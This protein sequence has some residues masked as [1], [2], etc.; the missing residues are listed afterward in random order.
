MNAIIFGHTGQDGWYLTKLLKQK[1]IQVYGVSRSK[2]DL[3]CS[4]DEYDKLVEVLTDIKPDYIFH[5]AAIS[6]T[7]HEYLF[8]N[9]RTIS[10]GVLNLL[11]ATRISCPHTRIFLSG[12]GLQFV[13]D[14][15]PLD[16]E[17]LFDA[18][19][20]YS[21][22]RNYTYFL[23]KYYRNKFNMNVFFGFF[24]THDSPKRSEYHMTQKIASAAKAA[25]RGENKKLFIG[26]L[27]VR[28]EY[29]Y[30]GDA[31]NAIWIL[32]NQDKYYDVVI[33]SGVDYSIRDWVSKCYGIV[34]LDWRDYIVSDNKFIAEYK[35]LISNPTRLYKMGWQPQVDF[36]TLATLMMEDV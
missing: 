6:T 14:G 34:N 29:L 8:D 21:V 2:T 13:N 5:F 33:G 36:N 1:G 35:R 28:K 12:S 23:G 31:V 32:V 3:K 18:T 7:K 27:E 26:D 11:E 20:S 9:H 4:L 17:C 10:T 15:H 16:E 30:A 25:A 19:S 24:F 22:E